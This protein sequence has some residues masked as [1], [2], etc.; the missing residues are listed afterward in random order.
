[1]WKN[2]AAVLIGDYLLSKGLLLAVKNEE[3][4]LLK[5][6]S[7][8]VEEMSEG[9]LLQ[10]EKSRKLDITESIYFDIISKK[11]AALI[12][13]CCESGACSTT[14]NVEFIKKMRLFGEKSGIAFQIKD[15]LLDYEKTSIIGKPSKIDIKEKKITLPLI[16]TLEKVSKNKRKEI[17]RII[18]TEESQSYFKVLETVQKEG[19][20]IYAEKVMNRYKNEAKEVL[21]S[22]ED[23]EAKKSLL[24]LL[25]YIVKRIK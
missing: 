23:S 16:Y 15:D 18:E 19:G 20:L 5:I 6:I 24:A 9:E 11:T 22:F 3:F 4:N 21:D 12:G 1:M 10:I 8:C 2:K 17:I 14:Q 13:A 25:E 7:G